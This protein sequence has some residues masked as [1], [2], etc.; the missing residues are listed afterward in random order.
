MTR[1]ILSRPSG[2]VSPALQFRTAR[3]QNGRVGT[4]PVF[5]LEL[6]R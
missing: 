1:R 2:I 3:V 5:M 6:E 4:R